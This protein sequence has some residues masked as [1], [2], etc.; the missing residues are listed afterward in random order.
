MV[1]RGTRHC[2]TIPK[3]YF[4]H[5]MQ[6]KIL[7][8]LIGLSA[9]LIGLYPL[10][11]FLLDEKFGLLNTKTDALLLNALWRLGFYTHI[12][13]GGIA[14]A[15][16]WVQFS[17]RIRT[18]NLKLHKTTGTVYLFAVLLSG[19]AGIGIGFFATG[20]LI[21]VL[22][23]VSLGI[24]WL[25]TTVM[26][27]IHVKNGAII[28]HQKFMIYSYAACFGAVTLRIW[29]PLL[30]LIFGD[31]SMAYPIVAWLSWVPNLM[32][33]HFLVKRL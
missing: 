26:A 4:N 28:S 9:I 16:G 22:G 20:G 10:S 2:W 1:N 3:N 14:L 31:F 21:P 11:Y 6:K 7:W 33:A 13:M 5:K 12:I 30:I 8:I 18:R 23:F 32:V 29:L 25:Y 24:I 15:I 19:T 27:Y 17:K